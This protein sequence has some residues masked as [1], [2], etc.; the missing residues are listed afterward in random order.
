[1]NGCRRRA[2]LYLGAP[3]SCRHAGWKPAIRYDARSKAR[4]HQ[5]REGAGTMADL[6]L[7]GIDLCKGPVVSIRHEYGVVAEA[8]LAARRPGQLALDLAAEQR[9]FAVR[10]GE[11]Q[12]RDE[13]GAAVLVGQFPLNPLHRD[14]EILIRPGP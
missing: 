5:F 1:A 3:A 7:R 9:H 6:M 14:A 12:H 13:M 8:A 10:P 2:A 11:R 4:P